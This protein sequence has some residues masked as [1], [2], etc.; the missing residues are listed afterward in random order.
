MASVSATPCAPP[1]QDDVQGLVTGTLFAG[2]GIFL[3]QLAGLVPGGTVGV[4]LLLHYA[5]GL[6]LPIALLTVNLPFY[7]LAWWRMGRAFTLR[8]VA[9]VGLLALVSWWLPHAVGLAR[10][11]G[12][13]SALLGGLLCGAGILFLFRHRASLG[14]FNVLALRLQE[15]LGWPAGK[16]Q[17]ALDAAVV[18]GGGWLAGDLRRL[19]LSVL[20]VLALNLAFVFNH[21]PGRYAG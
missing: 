18:L 12:V 9:A 3:M 8:T 15:S 5:S 14:G 11:D 13:L 4:A 7:A 6:P 17:L 1:L 16:V 19:A 21:R 20:A 2:F 10:I